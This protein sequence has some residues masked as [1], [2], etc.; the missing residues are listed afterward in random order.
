VATDDKEMP[1]ECWYRGEHC[2]DVPK[3]TDQNPISPSPA[4]AQSI[5]L[6]VLSGRLGRFHSTKHFRVRM[7]DRDFDIFDMEYVIRN[8]QCIEGGTFRAEHKNHEYTFRGNID[9]TDFEAA[10]A[11]SAEHDMIRSPLV[12]LVTGC[13]KTTSGRRGKTY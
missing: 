6:A 10:F 8:G 7:S 3:S 2:L 12:V 1:H 13:F 9:G 11:I 4:V 5:A